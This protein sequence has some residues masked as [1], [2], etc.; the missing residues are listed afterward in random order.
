M[1]FH[2]IVESST[3]CT[4][5]TYNMRECGTYLRNAAHVTCNDI[6]NNMIYR[7]C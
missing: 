4:L 1:I 3:Y 5:Y 7:E 6:N 2:Q